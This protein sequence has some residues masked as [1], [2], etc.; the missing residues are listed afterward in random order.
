MP[1]TSI[2]KCLWWM[3][4]KKRE[5]YDQQIRRIIQR[6]KKESIDEYSTTGDPK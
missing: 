4:M 5:K 2:K 3:M 6:A 1:I